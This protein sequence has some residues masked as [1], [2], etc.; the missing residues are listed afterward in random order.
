MGTI[1]I[2]IIAVILIL[3][4][5]GSLLLK[6]YETKERLKYNLDRRKAVMNYWRDLYAKEQV[7]REQNLSTHL[8]S[9]K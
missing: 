1:I 7:I 3:F 5:I 6:I 8:T 9:M 2:S 4:L